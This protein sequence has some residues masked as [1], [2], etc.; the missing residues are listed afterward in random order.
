MG[1]PKGSKNKHSKRRYQSAVGYIF[2]K[3]DHPNSDKRGY[4]PEHV[5]TMSNNLKR[6][7]D[8]SE[9]VHHINGVK[10]D[11]RIENLVVMKRAVHTSHHHKGF[12]K[13]NSLKNLTHVPSIVMH[14][15]SCK[16]CSKSFSTTGAK[17]RHNKNV[18]CSS[19]CST[20]YWRSK[21][22]WSSRT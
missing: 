17:Q 8:K 21:K 15:Y 6:P 2:I 9:V 19:S 11:N 7:I 18:F 1:R 22:Y 16:H 13:P 10:F 4:I 14:H 12:Y 20:T 5:L 3:Q